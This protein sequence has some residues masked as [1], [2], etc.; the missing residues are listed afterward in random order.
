MLPIVCLQGHG[1][2]HRAWLGGLDVGGAASPRWG[3]EPSVAGGP[4][5]TNKGEDS[6]AGAVP[7]WQSAIWF[8]KETHPYMYA[9]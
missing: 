3:P 9:K 4:H 8:L 5:G 6:L 2:E 7:S 1:G